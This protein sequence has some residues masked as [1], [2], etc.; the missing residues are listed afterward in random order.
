MSSSPTASCG[1]SDG[2]DEAISSDK[3]E[4]KNVQAH[5]S[6]SSSSSQPASGKTKIHRRSP[7][8]PSPTAT[9]D[10]DA[11]GSPNVFASSNNQVQPNPALEDSLQPARGTTKKHNLNFPVSSSPTA[12]CGALNSS[13]EVT[14]TDNDV[15]ENSQART[16]SPQDMSQS[17]SGTTKTHLQTFSV[18]SSPTADNDD[19]DKENGQART[20]SPQDL[21]QSASGTTKTHLQTF[22]VSSS[23]TAVC[24]APGIPSVSTGTE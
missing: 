23:P 6:S 2:P 17:A 22:S 4:N 10:G 3:D 19:I 5:T 7:V 20:E 18:S 9:A 8:S 16:Y 15:N 21:S 1:T 11:P 24:D 12:G 14:N 13:R